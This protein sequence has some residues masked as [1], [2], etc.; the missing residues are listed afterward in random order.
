MVMRNTP[1]RY[2][3]PARIFHWLTVILVLAMLALGLYMAQLDYTDW[4]LRVTVWHETIGVFVF[5]ITLARLGWRLYS[6]PPP[7]PPAPWVEHMAAHAAHGFLY[8]CLIAMP[9]LGWMG[10]NAY[11]FPVMWFGVIPLPNP[12]PKS[13]ALGEI[14]LGAHA[15]LAY[16]MV[17]AILVHAGAALYHHIV[18]RDP[19]LT[20]M[21]PG[22]KPRAEKF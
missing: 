18:R 13:D 21:V 7:L 1:T 9:L 5:L 19:I 6:P 4:K 10:S 20:R 8:F 17:A 22:L 14:L 3:A 11:G 16:A 15:L 2:G 12:L